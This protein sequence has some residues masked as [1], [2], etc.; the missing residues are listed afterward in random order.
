MKMID[1]KDFYNYL[2]KNDMDFFTGVPDS[3]LKEFCFC[4]ND[5]SDSGRHIIAANE[6]NAVAIACGYNIAS[7]K[8]GVVYMQNSGIGNAVN[9]LLSLADEKVYR[10]PMLLIIGYRGEPGT[11]DEPQHIKQGELTLPILETLGIKYIILGECYKEQ[12]KYCRR[13]MTLN[14]LPIALI[15]RKNSFSKYAYKDDRITSNTLTREQALDMII[16]KIGREDFIVSTTGKASREIYE[17]REKYGMPHSNDFLTVG[18]MGHTSSIAL[19]M[20]LFSKRN[21]FCIDGDGAF[22]MHMGA[23]A[24][25][26]QKCKS[27]FKY[28]LINNGCHESVGGQPTIANDIDIEKILYGFGCKKVLQAFGAEELAQKTDELILTEKSAL[29]IHTN[30]ESRDNLG[31]P[32]ISPICNKENFQMRLRNQNGSSDT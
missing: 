13:Y 14:E 2:I 28:I 27:N 25:A 19:G 21:I 22:I 30:R 10:I 12:I 24:A 1:T 5:L 17:I 16:R 8:F 18:S 11:A 29:V 31:R 32:D 23:A 9:P 20:S 15:V 3:L 7:G 4:V 26:M 6:G